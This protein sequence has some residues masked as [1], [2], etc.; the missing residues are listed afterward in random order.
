MKPTRC[1]FGLPEVKILGYILNANGIQTDPDKVA[2]IANLQQPTTVKEVRSM[3]GRCNYYRTSLP[4]Y[5]KVAE[6]LIELTRKQV[7]FTWNDE[8]Q[9]AFDKLKQLLIS[10]H[11]MAPPDIQKP[12]KLYTDAC[13]YAIGGILVQDSDD[14]VEKVIQYVSHTL[15]P[16][17]R[18]WATIEKEAYA[19]V[20]C[21]DKLKPYLYGA[22]FNV[23]TNHKPL[24]SLF[25]KSMNNTTIQRRE[26]TLAESAATISYRPGK[27]QVRADMLS[28]IK[29]DIDNDIAIIDTDEPFDPDTLPDD[30]HVTDT[31]PLIHDGL[32]L[33]TVAND[34][35]KEFPELWQRGKEEDDE[36]YDIL[37]GVLYSAKPPNLTAPLYP[38][39]VLPTDYR[40]AVIDRAHRECGHLALWKTIRRITE[41]YVWTGLRRDV[42]LQL[43]HCAVCMTHNRHFQRHTMGE[44]PTASYPIQIVA[45]DLIGPLVESPLGNKYILTAVDFCT[46]WAEAFPI[47]SK[48]N[49]N[50]WNAFTNGFISRHGCPEDLISDLGSEFTALEFERYLEQLGIEHR[51]TTPVH[52]RPPPVKRE[53]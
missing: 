18:K 15:S 44:M 45:V 2:A 25:T 9:E 32:N 16:T 23:Y 53:D 43:R 37:N 14:G 12:Y 41:A 31:L 19:V 8:R 22:Q 17:Q 39:L 46:G 38:Q 29:H 50:V 13:D 30:D 27:R 20:Y 7:R 1:A 48:Y 52:P 35:R 34:Q 47:P 51:T 33:Q 36:D 6:P 21:I 11:V 24:L 40:E 26:V 5:A 10:S 28:R 4:N 49:E 42:R 3:L